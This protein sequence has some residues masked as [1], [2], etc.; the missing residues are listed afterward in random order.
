M[1]VNVLLAFEPKAVTAGMQT[2]MIRA[3][4]T[5]YS[6]AVGPSSRFTKL[7][8]AFANDFIFVRPLRYFGNVHRRSR[9]LA[10]SD[11]LTGGWPHK[12]KRNAEKARFSS[13]RPN[14]MTERQ[15]RRCV[16]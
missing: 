12:S 3:S 8:T 4:M 2:T 10:L 11:N 6:T 9:M 14:V 16:N 7:I 13:F 15:L 1:V 5:A